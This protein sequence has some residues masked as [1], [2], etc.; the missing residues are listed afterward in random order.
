[1]IHD[2]AVRVAGITLNESFAAQLHRRRSGDEDS[3][4]A[5]LGQHVQTPFADALE[6]ELKKT[7]LPARRSI[8]EAA[9]GNGSKLMV[10]GEF[11]AIDEG[12]ESRRMM[13]GFGRGGSD[14]KAHVTISLVSD[15]QS[16]VMLEFD[17]DSRSNKM[18]GALVTGGGSL[19]VG[20]A[21]SALGERKSNVEADATR[22]GTL[23]AKQIEGLMT[24]QRWVYVATEQAASNGSSG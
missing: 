7:H 10:A 9:G 20:T 23:V 2:F 5:I 13:I 19:A 21:G 16:T 3:T 24:R 17:M 18:P 14:I 11:V 15:G 1:V 6:K 8:E 12:N 22:M 4:P